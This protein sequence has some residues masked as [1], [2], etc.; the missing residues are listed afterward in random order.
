MSKGGL[1]GRSSPCI[2]MCNHR[3]F[4]ESLPGSGG[5]V[6]STVES[7]HAEAPMRWRTSLLDNG[8][9]VWQ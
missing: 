7:A 5:I 2:Y 6:V 8:L 1:Q 3:I 9:S 4:S